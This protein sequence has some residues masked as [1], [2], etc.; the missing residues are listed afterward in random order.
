M[1]NKISNQQINEAIGSLNFQSGNVTEENLLNQ[2]SQVHLITATI[3]QQNIPIMKTEF[4]DLLKGTDV[5]LKLLSDLYS[6]KYP[7]TNTSQVTLSAVQSVLQLFSIPNVA[8]KTFQA[9]LP[10]LGKY[11][12]SPHVP[13]FTFALFLFLNGFRMV[14][15]DAGGRETFVD[16]WRANIFFKIVT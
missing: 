10:I 12:E 1:G 9:S 13:P 7:I 11:L 4:K 5:I 6:G 16:L 2:L 14:G 15:V 3:L 8:K